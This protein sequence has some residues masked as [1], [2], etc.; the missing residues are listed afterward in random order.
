MAGL[1]HAHLLILLVQTKDHTQLL[2]EW[3]GEGHSAS[4]PLQSSLKLHSEQLPVP[5]KFLQFLFLNTERAFEIYEN[6]H[7]SKISCYM[8]SS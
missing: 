1:G 3:D 8:V 7:H 6:L 4:K 2:R 5:F